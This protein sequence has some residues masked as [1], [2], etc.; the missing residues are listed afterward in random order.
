MEEIIHL[1][2]SLWSDWEKFKGRTSE[3][4]RH[5]EEVCMPLIPLFAYIWCFSQVIRDIDTVVQLCATSRHEV[6][7]SLAT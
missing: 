3:S 2:R 5:V 1:M 4:F 7:G 6:F